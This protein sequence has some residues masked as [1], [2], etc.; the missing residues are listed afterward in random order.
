MAQM[1]RGSLQQWSLRKLRG[2]E[3]MFFFVSDINGFM[4]Y[5]LLPL[6]FFCWIAGW[7]S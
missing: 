3:D 6:E 2:L 1:K 4:V 7:Q 5:V